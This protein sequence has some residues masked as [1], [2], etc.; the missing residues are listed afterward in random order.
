MGIC[1]ATGFLSLEG[2][3]EGGVGGIQRRQ[4]GPSDDEDSSRVG[5]RGRGA[6]RNKESRYSAKMKKDLP[7]HPVL[8]PCE[9]LGSDGA[10]GVHGQQSSPD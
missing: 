3:G 2:L 9:R 1:A 10:A 5:G 8:L 4:G 7:Q 6:Q